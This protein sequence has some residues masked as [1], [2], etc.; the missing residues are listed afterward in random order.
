M[1]SAIRCFCGSTVRSFLCLFDLRFDLEHGFEE[2][3]TLQIEE[4]YIKHERDEEYRESGGGVFDEL[5]AQRSAADAFDNCHDDMT[6]IEHGN[7]E[8]VQDREIH[9]QQH[10]EAQRQTIITVYLRRKNGHDAN[11]SAKVARFDASVSRVHKGRDDT[12]CLFGMFPNLSP[13]RG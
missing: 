5:H 2:R 4:R 12:K 6:A 7:W 8:E 1:A 10:Q 13:R 9:V 11:R 3:E